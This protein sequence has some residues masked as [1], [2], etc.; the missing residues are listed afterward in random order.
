MADIK[1]LGGQRF[2]DVDIKCGEGGI[3]TLDT[4]NRSMTV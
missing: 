1:F 2:E 3:R 4:P